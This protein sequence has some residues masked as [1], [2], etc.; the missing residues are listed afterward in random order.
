MGGD[1]AEARVEPLRV[2]TA[3][4][5]REL[6]HVAPFL[7][8]AFDRPEEELPAEAAATPPTID[9]HRFDLRPKPSAIRQIGDDR[10]LQRGDDL[11]RD[12]SDDKYLARVG[13]DRRERR[14][15]RLQQRLMRAFTL[16]AQ[17]IVGEEPDDRREVGARGTA[18]LHR[19][20]TC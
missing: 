14:I 16:S 11:A 18:D 1:E 12:L 7:S 13:I 4:V 17:V 20:C 19:A 8:G 10:Q 5:G 2:G 9:A 15:I 3:G 6:H